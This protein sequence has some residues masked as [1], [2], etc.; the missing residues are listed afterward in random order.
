MSISINEVGIFI[1]I[2][3][4]VY[5]HR[6]SPSFQGLVIKLYFRQNVTWE[7]DTQTSSSH[8]ENISCS[9]HLPTKTQ[10]NLCLCAPKYL[11]PHFAHCT[12]FDIFLQYLS[13]MAELGEGPVPPP[14]PPVPQ[15]SQP[16]ATDPPPEPQ[17]SNP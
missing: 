16:R 2:L 3:V 5:I 8:D 14:K 9:S 13:L 7:L 10:N 4:L 12:D 17:G 1:K 15:E 6:Y 11:R